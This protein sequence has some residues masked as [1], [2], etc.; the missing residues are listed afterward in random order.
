MKLWY[1]D[2]ILILTTLHN[3]EV[4]IKPVFEKELLF[5]VQTHS[6]NTDTLGTFTGEIERKLSQ[7]ESAKEKALMGIKA[8]LATCGIGSEGSFGPHPRLPFAACNFETLYFI[9]QDNEIE[10]THTHL[11]TKTNYDSEVFSK[12]QELESFLKQIQFPS[13]AVIVK[14]DVN[15]GNFFCFK[16]ISKEED[17][18]SAFIECQNKSANKKVFIQTDMRAHMNPTRMKVIEE[19]ACLLVQKLLTLCPMC[20]TPGFSFKETQ[21][22]KLCSYCHSITSLALHEVHGC[23]KCS[24]T[25]QKVIDDEIKASPEFCYCCNP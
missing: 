21:G 11:S 24:F 17:L 16:G 14:P 7:T 20:T 8:S 6:F 1:K 22:H 3:K 12:W 18:K 23:I 13:H 25:L 10:I 9:D 5:N 15:E 19:T 4:A 2:K